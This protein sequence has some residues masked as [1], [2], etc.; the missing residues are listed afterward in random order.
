MLKR[1]QFKNWRSLRDVEIDNLTPITVFIGANSSGKSNILD[2]LHF[3][4]YATEKGVREAVFAWRGRDKIRTFGIE[5]SVEVVFDFLLN[6]IIE[7]KSI[8]LFDATES[9]N[10]EMN[11]LVY[12]TQDDKIKASLDNLIFQRWQF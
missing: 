6:D 10:T 3:M 11:L 4:R 8:S 1:L 2:A 9:I 12:Y 5:G 7:K